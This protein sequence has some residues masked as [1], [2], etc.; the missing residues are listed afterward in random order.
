MKKY[1]LSAIMKNAWS[2]FGKEEGITFGEALHRAW[3]S[4]K[5]EPVNAK[6]IE[7]AKASAGILE[8]VRTW[9]GWKQAGFTVRHGSKNLFQVEL[10]WGS[11]GDG[12]TYKASFFGASQ[13]E[14]TEDAA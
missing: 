8:E 2:I 3:L 5:A 14:A 4:A 9:Y 6:R 1:N 13:V 11:K 10:I 12:K 7:D